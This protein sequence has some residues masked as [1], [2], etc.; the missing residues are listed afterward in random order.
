MNNM[1][2]KILSLLVLLLT[3]ATGAWADYTVT[4]DGTKLQGIAVSKGY[5]NDITT[6]SMT[7]DGITITANE[8]FVYCN[9]SSVN[10]NSG[11]ANGIVFSAENNIK[12]I[13]ITSTGWSKFT[14]DGSSQG[15]GGNHTYDVSP[16]ATSYGFE[17]GVMIEAITSIEFNLEGEPPVEVTPGSSANTWTFSMPGSDVMLT[18]VYA[19]KAAF[20]TSGEPNAID[21]IIAGEAKAIVNEGTVAKAG[22]TNTQGTVMY[23]TTTD[24]NMTKEQARDASGWTSTVPTGAVLTGGFDKDQTVYVWY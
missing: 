24:A 3:A 16:A 15:S 19:P 8:G 12:S 5:G 23:L 17:D 2:N 18:P 9:N 6:E 20:A 22:S 7:V 13:T 1:R 10:F 11:G 14:P 21:G 4:W